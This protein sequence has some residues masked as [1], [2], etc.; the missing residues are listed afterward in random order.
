MRPA[1]APIDASPDQRAAR[2][3][4]QVDAHP[5]KMR[6]PQP[7][8]KELRRVKYRKYATEAMSGT[9]TSIFAMDSSSRISYSDLTVISTPI[10]ASR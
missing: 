1:F 3:H 4:F 8:S 10:E 5:L 9:D 7:E 6:G 2:Y